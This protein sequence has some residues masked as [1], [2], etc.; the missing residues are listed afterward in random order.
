M[1]TATDEEQ[2]S[3]V[4]GGLRGEYGKGRDLF[5]PGWRPAWVAGEAEP[6]GP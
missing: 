5:L 6:A 1:W 3:D 2:S 4:W